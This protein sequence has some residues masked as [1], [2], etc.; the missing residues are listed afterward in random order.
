MFKLPFP[1]SWWHARFQEQKQHSL[2]TTLKPS[3]S[4]LFSSSSLSFVFSFF[5]SVCLCLYFDDTT[6]T[7]WHFQTQ[8]F[9]LTAD[10]VTPS[11]LLTGTWK[12][13]KNKWERE[14][15][16]DLLYVHPH[17]LYESIKD[18]ESNGTTL[19]GKSVLGPARE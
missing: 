9:I 18:Y 7:K 8:I 17:K 1:S 12:S 4:V 14:I 11:I 5:L 6:T 13:G 2:I 19:S 10:F 15:V 3:F 16:V